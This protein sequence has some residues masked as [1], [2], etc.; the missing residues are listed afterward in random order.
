MSRD[1]LDPIPSPA[2]PGGAP[3]DPAL[4]AAPADALVDAVREAA[5]RGDLERVTD[6][7]GEL[8]ARS[9]RRPVE[10]ALRAA[11]EAGVEPLPW[12]D[13]ARRA[14]RG[15]RRETRGTHHLYVTVV[16][17]YVRGGRYGVYVGE[18]R[19]RPENRLAQ[20]RAGVRA[21]K[22]GHR[23]VALLPSLVAHLNPL[24]RE[25]AK[26]LEAVLARVLREAGLRVEGGH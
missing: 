12:L 24:G 17:G 4:R 23:M 25:E 15:L 8:A 3:R 6:C 18:S 19:Y 20:H 22:V 11:A 26:T 5:R 10:R 7:V 16:D 13:A 14:A 1:T 9:R 21:A 2:A